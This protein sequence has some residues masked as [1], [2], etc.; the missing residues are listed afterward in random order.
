MIFRLVFC[1]DQTVDIVTSGLFI[2]VL[3]FIGSRGGEGLRARSAM[4][5]IVPCISVIVRDR[6]VCLVDNRLML[7]DMYV[8]QRVA[9]QVAAVVTCCIVSLAVE[10]DT[11]AGTD[12]EGRIYLY[13][14]ANSQVQVVEDKIAVSQLLQTRVLFG[15]IGLDTVPFEG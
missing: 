4:V 8:H 6:S 10:P 7:N 11:A 5:D 13:H 15:L 2:R 1:Q 14:I 3:I 9:V 12:R